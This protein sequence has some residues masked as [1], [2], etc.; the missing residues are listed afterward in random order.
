MRGQKLNDGCLTTSVVL[1]D[2][3]LDDK[4]PNRENKITRFM[5]KREIENDLDE[6]QT[7]S[8]VDVT[9]TIRD[10]STF[11]D[12]K[13]YSFSLILSLDFLLKISNF[14]QMDDPDPNNKQKQ[15]AAKP[16]VQSYTCKCFSNI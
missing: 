4:R 6:N 3:H 16:K 1:C 12:L 7:K 2:I 11:V 13:V 9:L 8:M 5:K 15:P 10:N 14:F